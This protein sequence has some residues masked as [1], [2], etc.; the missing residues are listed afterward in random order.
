[1]T[2]DEIRYAAIGTIAN[3]PLGTCILDCLL[4]GIRAYFAYRNSEG[5]VDGR[6]LVVSTKLDDAVGQN[7]ERALEVISANDTFGVFNAGLASS[8]LADLDKAG[9]PSY[10]WA[11]DFAAM[12]GHAS[13]FGNAGVLCLSCVERS[14]VYAAQLVKAKRI[15]V[16]GYG[17]SPVTKDCVKG[18]VD[19]IRRFGAQTD[20]SVVYSRDDLPFGVTNGLGPEVS[21]MKAAGV[22]LIVGCWD[23]N[24]SKTLGEELKRQGI[25]DVPQMSSNLYDAGFVAAS[26]DLFEG[27]IVRVPFRPFESVDTGALATYKK[28][29][30]RTGAKQTEASMYGWIDA[31]LAY[32]GLKRAGPGFDRAKVIAA[33]NK[34]TAYSADGLINPIDWSRQHEAPTADDP[35]THGYAKECWAFV[36]VKAGR[37][38]MVGSATKPFECWD[39]T[40]PLEWSKPTPTN[41]SG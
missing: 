17:A 33:T 20:E 32:Q 23:L 40:D 34:L 10:V 2:K 3:N 1:V 39:I 9:I 35:V 24:A 29:M 28:W 6:R 18:G 21:A 37:F 27:T 19:S 22:Q 16:L 25:G 11:I 15:A 14:T 26:P 13:V 31:D 12:S 38:Q 36:R 4:D 5:G 8:G 30:D 7:Q 41:I